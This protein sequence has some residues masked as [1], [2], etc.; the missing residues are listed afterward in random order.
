MWFLLWS[1]DPQL[2]W[3]SLSWL[4]PQ[5]SLQ[6]RTKVILE[7]ANAPTTPEADEFF[8]KK[9]IVVIPDILANAGGVVVSYFEWVQNLQSFKWTLEQVVTELTRTM[10]K[11]YESVV[12]IATTKK[13]PLRTAAFAL[14]VG[15]VAKAMTLRGL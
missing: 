12:N 5:T 7:A 10:T 8:E 15:R 13:V 4:P 6:D 3:G 9:G 11:A 1:I 14:G 2:D